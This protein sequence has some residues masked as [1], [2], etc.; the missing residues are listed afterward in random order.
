MGIYIAKLDLRTG[1]IIWKAA[2]GDKYI[3]DKVQ[4]VGTQIFGGVSL[5]GSNIL[6]MTGTDDSKA[7]AIDAITG[8]ELWSFK[9]DAA[10]SAPPTIYETNGKQYVSFIST[11]GNYHSYKEIAS[12]IYTFGI[13]D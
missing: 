9:M 12:T 8:N 2:H 10:G 11:G 3:N 7:Y 5:N 13:L 4:K 1:K 6:F